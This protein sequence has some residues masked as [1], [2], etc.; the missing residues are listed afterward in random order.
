MANT[1]IEAVPQIV[2]LLAPLSPEDRRRAIRASL[3]LLGD[4][5]T[6]PVGAGGPKDGE[7]DQSEDNG[8]SPRARAWMK[9]N[10]VTIDEIQ[11]TFHMADG[12]AEV[13][14]SDIP[15]KNGKEQTLAAYVLTGIAA[16]LTTGNATFD[17]DSARGVCKSSGCFNL[18]NHAAYLKE[19]GNEFTGSKENGWTL[20]TPGLKRGAALVKELGRPPK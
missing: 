17:D 13:I 5:A 8:L 18:A 2:N 10:D 1:P 16:L 20:T 4:E 14:A 15:G 6:L 9:Q 19:K 11:Q 7:Q 12:V 3:A